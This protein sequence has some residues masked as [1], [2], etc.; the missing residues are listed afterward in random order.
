[1]YNYKKSNIEIVRQSL[2]TLYDNTPVKI[3]LTT[4]PITLLDTLTLTEF[5]NNVVEITPRCLCG[6]LTGAS[7]LGETA[8]CCN[9]VVSDYLGKYKPILWVS[10]PENKKLFIAPQ[11]W[12]TINGI[13]KQGR[14]D[15]LAYLTNH[16]YKSTVMTPKVLDMMM[17]EMTDFQRNYT[18]VAENLD[19]ILIYLLNSS[20]MYSKRDRLRTLLDV[21]TKNKDI[22]MSSKMP[23]PSKNLFLMET[24][25][26]SNKKTN[27]VTGVV[28]SLVLNYRDAVDSGRDL[29]MATSRLISELAT[30]YEMN[31]ADMI[32]GKKRIVRS[33]IFGTKV[34]GSF[35]T[36]MLPISGPHNYDDFI[37]PWVLAISVFRPYIISNLF[38]TGRYRY[39][40]ISIKIDKAIFKYDKEIDD[41]FKQL[42]KESKD[43]NGKGIC[44]TMGRNPSQHR[45]SII[46]VYVR[47]IKT[48]PFDFSSEYS[49]MLSPS[50]N[51]D[52]DGDEHNMTVAN[53]RETERLFENFRIHYGAFT[54]T[55][56]FTISKALSIADT[57]IINLSCYVMDAKNDKQW[58]DKDFLS[59]VSA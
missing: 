8:I 46:T 40:E 56:P 27:L 45:F 23:I 58:I 4:M 12:S 22:I 37:M 10:H 50:L 41:I 51:G 21:Y 26:F 49:I 30:T 34:P 43:Y 7:Y 48:D 29:N 15:S 31:V 13:I 18:W 39:T 35:R 53:D 38:K 55:K 16:R 32:H 19:K 2:D 9:T 20:V 1:M 54:P 24:S 6:T 36:V 3:D 28:K 11:F 44:I 52:F 14:F 5:T 57:A 25:A 42:V 33:N 17:N 59:M 47:E